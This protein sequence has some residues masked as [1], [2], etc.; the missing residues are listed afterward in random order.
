MRNSPSPDTPSDILH[1]ALDSR[2]AEWA[3]QD[4]KTEK[5]F[6]PHLGEDWASRRVALDMRQVEMLNSQAIGW[7]VACA[8]DFQTAGG[9]IAL[10]NLEDGIEKLLRMMCLD[11][12]LNLCKDVHEAVAVLSDAGNP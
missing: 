4:L 3:L 12:V 2:L 9:Q 8:R 10:H 5:V 7:L 1:F 11:Q 6:A